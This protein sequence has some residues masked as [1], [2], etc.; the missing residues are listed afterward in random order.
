[1]PIADQGTSLFIFCI[2]VFLLMVF[3][4]LLD[5]EDDL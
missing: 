4:W 1:M 2:F 5:K 3:A